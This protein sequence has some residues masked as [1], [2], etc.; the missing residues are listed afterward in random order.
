MK[1]NLRKYEL[2]QNILEQVFENIEYSSENQYFSNGLEYFR[3]CEKWF[4]QVEYEVFCML[5]NKEDELESVKKFI[6]FRISQH[7]IQYER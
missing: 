1:Y 6:T 2:L 5:T 3:E 4:K 7:H